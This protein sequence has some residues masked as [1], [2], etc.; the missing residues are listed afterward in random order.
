VSFKP[1]DVITTNFTGVIDTKRRPAVIL[2]SDTYHS[3]RPDIIA[4]LITT[5]IKNLSNTDY[6]LQDWKEAGLHAAS[7]FR[8]FIVTLS[9]SSKSVYVGHLSERDWRGVRKAVK[10]SLAKLDDNGEE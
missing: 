10:A 4:G 8:T 9:S 1:G 7:A 5:K 3:L 2:S 6:V